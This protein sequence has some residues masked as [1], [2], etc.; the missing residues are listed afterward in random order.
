MIKRSLQASAEGIKKAKQAFKR[1]GWTQEYLAAEV[2]LETRQSIWKFFTGKP[3]DRHVFND[4]CSALELDT[5]E[6]S[7]QP[8]EV[9][10]C[11]ERY[12]S[13]S[14][15]IDDLVQKL[16]SIHHDRIQAQCGILHLLDIARPIYLNDIYIDINVCEEIS[17]KQWL[18]INDLQKPITP[19]CQKPIPG[20]EA[21]T[22]YA[23]MILLGKPGSGKTTFLQSVALSC[24]QGAFQPDYVPIFINVKS[25]A[26]DVKESRQISLFQYIHNYL[27]N[28]GISETDMSTL[29]SHGRA[30]V[31]I[32]G[33]DEAIGE[34][35]DKTL[36]K[37]RI[38]INKFYKNK[39][40]ISCR[41]AL[42]CANFHGFTEVEIADLNPVQ[43]A[44]F[45]NK[46]FLSVAKNSPVT[47]QILTKTIMQKLDLPENSHILE[48]SNNPL[49]L[50]F[51][52]LVFQSYTDFPSHH[53]EIYKQA[54]DLLLVRWYEVKGIEYSQVVP[55]LSLLDKIKLLSRI[56]ASSFSQGDYLIRQTRLQQII[57]DYLLHQKNI[58]TDTD[59]LEMQ[60]REV[61][62]IIE[63][64][65]GLLIERAKGIYSF[66]YVIFQ[67]YFTAKE[68]VANA[69][70]QKLQELA[71]NLCDKRWRN[72]LLLSVWML[73]PADE[74]LKLIK[75][76][77]DNLAISNI[78][79][80]HFLQWVERKSSQVSSIYQGSSV[81]AFYFTIA[82]P[83]EH[84]LACNQDLAITLEHQFTGSLSM[85][86][87]LDLVLT[88]ALTVSLTMTADIFYARLS[89][90]NLA[91]DVKHLLVQEI[92]LHT[93][94]QHLKHQLPATTEGR[95]GLK[96]WWLANGKAWTEELRNLMI[97][98]RQ[99]GLNWQFNQQDLQD[100][101]QYWDAN[102]LL[103]DCLNCTR[104][105]SPSLR[106]HLETS[107]FL[108]RGVE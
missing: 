93:S 105:V 69:N 31:L 45:V 75:Q 85:E 21:I 33:L 100:L 84:P 98:A 1:K 71:V 89:T 103:I 35:Y 30:L 81:R 51:C 48:L 16:R 99:I 5:S 46:W 44:E 79:L 25:F 19:K 88:H 24:A 38:F 62:K 54:L 17:R 101:Q 56:A 9:S 72:V 83:P 59:A 73:K 26:E 94:L 37:I 40:V 77:I 60:S 10:L 22:K 86:L 28:L 82:L 11:L 92:P 102:K 23:K 107:L 7:Q 47:S 42:Y 36:N 50:N 6:I 57:T 90:L 97:N 49:L 65:H 3:I 2:G 43:I 80:Y 39:I 14:L 104:D 58:T 55:N 20:L 29:L 66:S 13:N 8:A 4:I 15:D 108:A 18:E 74:L 63:L 41:S 106:S 67:E 53:F 70:S 68:I 78:K 95:E 64:Q 12:E 96:N 52:C 91:L 32:D 76:K 27:L 34:N 87:A 61:I